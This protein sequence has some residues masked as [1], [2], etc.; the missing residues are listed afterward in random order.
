[1]SRSTEMGCERKWDVRPSRLS[2][3]TCNPIRSIVENLQV[4][5]NPNK[6]F[7]PLSIG[8]PT[9]FGNLKTP[10]NVLQAICDSVKLNE[11]RSYGPTI[12]HFDARRAVAE[13]S[14]HQGP[15]T[16]DDVILCSG[17]SHAIEMVVSVIAEAGRNIIVPR[18]GYMIH[19]TIGE[20]MGI[21][22]KY[23]DLL[24]DENWK[25]DLRSLES[26]IDINTA[27]IVVNNPSNPCGSVYTEEHLCEILEIASKYC[28]PIIADEIY[29]HFIFSNH[30]FTPISVLSK[31]VPILTCSGITKRFLVPGWRMGWVIIHDRQNILGK[32]FRKGLYN[33][34][35]RLL[36][37]NTLIQRILPL[38]LKSTPLDYFDDMMAFVESQAKYACQAL[39]KVPSLRPIMPQGSMYMMIEIKISCFPKFTNELAFIKSLLA[40]QS[41]LCIPGTCFNYPNFMRIVLTVPEEILHEACARIIEFCKEHSDVKSKDQN[42]HTAEHVIYDSTNL[43]VKGGI[44]TRVSLIT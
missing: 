9:A 19:T 21:T 6:K 7:I 30:K 38:I 35:S 36:G 5:P 34:S 20:G 12:G 32:E 2:L 17:C 3:K 28:V 41:I 39:S 44:R 26:L 8:D 22:I 27:A 16:A 14:S 23:Y 31:D 42:G 10:D 37:P 18:P 43:Y 40:E 4:K 25:V 13:Y 1:M 33:I 11:S 29:E 15:V 24:P